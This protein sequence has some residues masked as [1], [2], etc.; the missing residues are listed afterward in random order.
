MDL[1]ALVQELQAS[2]PGAVIESLPTGV[3]IKKE[4]AAKAFSLL[5]NELSFE[6]L[7]CLTAVDRK[8]TI[9]V[10]YHVYSFTHRLMATLKVVLPMDDL[11]VASVTGLWSSADWFEREVYDL[12]G[13]RFEGHPDLRRI[14]NPDGWTDHPLRK[15]FKGA[16]VVPKPV[17]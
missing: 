9:E 5:K 14:L 6:S 7:Q 4:D 3:V 1:A 2:I 15:D 17:K 8:E 13:V 16:G 12:F 11:N 10:V